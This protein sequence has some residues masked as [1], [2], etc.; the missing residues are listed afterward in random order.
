[1]INAIDSTGTPMTAPA[2]S[3][4]GDPDLLSADLY[5]RLFNRSA[6]FMYRAI[7]RPTIPDPLE[8]ITV[9]VRPRDL[10]LE[11]A[12]AEWNLLWEAG[13]F[14]RRMFDEDELPGVIG[15]VADRGDHNVLFVPRTRSRYFEYAPLFHLLPRRA[16]EQH[17]LP[18]IEATSW[19]Y[20]VSHREEPALPSDFAKRLARAWSGQVWRHLVPGSRMRSFSASDPIKLLAHNLDFWLPPVTEVMQRI[21]RELPEVDNG[22]A[23]EVPRLEDGSLLSGA[24]MANPRMGSELW[25]GEVQAA[26]VLGWVVDEADADGRL[27]GILDAVRSNRVEDD[28]SDHWSFAREDFERKLHRKRSKVKVRFVELSD[29]IP[30]QGPETEVVGSSVVADFLA[31]LNE[32]D[33]QIVV[34]LNSGTTKLT[35]VADVLGYSNHSAVSKRLARIRNDA[36]RLLDQC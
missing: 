2:P 10:K 14:R 15:R 5:P 29:T 8:F 11:L 25:C 36:S 21:L 1:M 24:V 19:P 20:L 17:G 27:R 7:V 32:R 31:L 12:I 26:D 23:N 4:G 18:L 30:V 3:T 35:D 6:G 9:P 34:L 16:V 22:I 13:Q 33:R 28:F